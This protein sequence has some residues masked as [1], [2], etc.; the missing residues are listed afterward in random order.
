[1]LPQH[2]G[3]NL[4]EM[5]KRELEKRQI[6]SVDDIAE[7][8]VAAKA[9]PQSRSAE[10][11][12]TPPPSFAGQEEEVPPQLKK[13]REL[14]SEGLEGLIP[15]GSALL[16]LG[17]S[18]F[19]AFGPFIVGVVLAFAAI[20]AVR[21]RSV[22]KYMLSTMSECSAVSILIRALIRS[23]GLWGSVCSYWPT[24]R[25]PAIL[26]PSRAVERAHCRPH[27]PDVNR[28]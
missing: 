4:D 26:G 23:T 3:D 1:M 24:G 12:S 13:S 17:L 6:S 25:A 19:L 21:E 11:R 8:P 5:F 27:D 28:R 2:P 20:Y 10:R 15:R 18:F 14:N 7:E 16:Q 22:L 9:A